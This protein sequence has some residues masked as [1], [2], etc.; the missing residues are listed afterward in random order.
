M[1]NLLKNLGRTF[2]DTVLFLVPFAVALIAVVVLKN[3]HHTRE[4][5][6][7]GAM[8]A[9]IVAVIV[10]SILAGYLHKKGVVR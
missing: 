1:Q 8:G 6:V 3:S 5:C 7:G 10:L 9:F 2:I 4:V